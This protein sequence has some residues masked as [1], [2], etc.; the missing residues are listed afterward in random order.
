MS[1]AWARVKIITYKGSFHKGRKRSREVWCAAW[2]YTIS[3]QRTY[4]K[5]DRN[6]IFFPKSQGNVLLQLRHTRQ[7]NLTLVLWE[8]KLIFKEE[9]VLASEKERHSFL[10]LK[11]AFLGKPDGAVVK[12][13]RSASGAQFGSQVWT[14]APLIKPCC[15]RHP[16]YKVEKDGHGC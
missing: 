1:F 16:T 15:G 13:A 2:L 11:N 3:E 5:H 4:I 7:V 10:S 6:T 9:R 12:F 8:E 14:Y